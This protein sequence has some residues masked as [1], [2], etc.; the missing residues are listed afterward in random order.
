M[1]TE[2]ALWIVGVGI[3][4]VGVM[5]LAF[6]LGYKYAQTGGVAPTAE[7]R[8]EDGFYCAVLWP[9]LVVLAVVL[10]LPFLLLSGAALLMGPIGSQVYHLT[11]KAF[12]FAKGEVCDGRVQVQSR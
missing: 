1:L 6:D 8:F 11:F 4:Y 2:V 9:F 7:S 3:I 5:P 10:I 12:R